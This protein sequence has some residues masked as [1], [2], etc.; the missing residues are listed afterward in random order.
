MTKRFGIA[1]LSALF[2]IGTLAF[3]QAQESQPATQNSTTQ[4]SATQ[5]SAASSPEKQGHWKHGRQDPAKQVQRM[6]KKLNL[7]SDQQSKVQSILED[8]QKQLETLRQDKSLSREDRGAKFNELRQTSS[9]QIR[10][11]LSEDQQKKFDQMQQKRE[12]KM[13]AHRAK[14]DG[15][16]PSADS[17]PKQ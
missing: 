4:D 13:A 11:V 1:L 5:G 16:Q 8:Q 2:V 9:A 10:A 12:Q 7:S 15:S 6:S 14:K 3:A 17:Q